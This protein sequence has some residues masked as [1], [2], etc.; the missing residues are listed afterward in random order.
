MGKDLRRLLSELTRDDGAMPPDLQVP[1]K[2]LMELLVRGRLLDMEP[3]RAV[4]VMP[5]SR[6]LAGHKPPLD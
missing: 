3:D 5:I 6:C 4:I 1:G 2:A